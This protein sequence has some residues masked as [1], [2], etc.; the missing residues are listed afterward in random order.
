MGSPTGR[1]TRWGEAGAPQRRGL[2]NGVPDG[3]TDP[4]G[5]GGRAVAARA[6]RNEMEGQ[7]ESSEGRA[8]RSGGSARVKRR[9]RPPWWRVSTSGAKAAPAVVE[10]L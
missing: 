7:H 6:A 4:V 8:R 5:G 9:L 2:A 10:G 3:S 1:Q